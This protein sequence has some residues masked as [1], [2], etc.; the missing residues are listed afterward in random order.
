MKTQPSFISF[1]PITVEP[2][3]SGHPR[4]RDTLSSIIRDPR[5]VR[6]VGRK[7]RDES[8]RALSPV[9]ENFR[10]AVSPD[11]PYC[12]WVSVDS[13]IK[14]YRNFSPRGPKER[15]KPLNGSSTTGSP[16]SK[17]EHQHC[18]VTFEI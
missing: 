13:L 8:F 16:S 17:Y 15:V 12:P 4:R 18:C 2:L 10:R 14:F 5:A 7:R 1:E 6:R 3:F 9:L 11:R